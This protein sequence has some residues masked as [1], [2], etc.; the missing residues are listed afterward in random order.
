MYN[1]STIEKKS[2]IIKKLK[3]DDNAIKLAKIHI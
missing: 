1:I 3:K 2:K